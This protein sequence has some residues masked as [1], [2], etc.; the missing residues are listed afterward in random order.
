MK[1]VLEKAFNLHILSHQEIV[2]LLSPNEYDEL[3]FSYADEVRKKY[4]GDEIYLRALIE[5][6][7]ICQNNCLYCGIRAQNSKISR[8]KLSFEQIIET[9]KKA[10]DLGYKTVV[11]QSGEGENFKTEEIVEVI[12]EIKKMD[13]AVTLSLGE[14]NFEQYEAYKKAGADRYLIRIETTDKN[15][16][17]KM[18]PK[19]NFENRVRCLTDLK[20]LGY[21]VGT[22]SLVGLPNQTLSSLADDILFFKEIDADMIG[23]GPFIATENTPLENQQNG[24]FNL[25]RKMISIVRLL[26]PNINIPATTAMETIEKKGRILV[27]K[28]GANV[29]MPNITPVEYRQ[30]YSIY[31]DKSS[32]DANNLEELKNEFAKIGRKI[33]SKKG[34]R[35][36]NLEY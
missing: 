36:D 30:D 26:M 4:I 32:V 35:K 5:F 23:L 8:Y 3:L 10:C 1:K 17:E 19:M 21:E 34:F 2:D 6:S 29:V 16:Y 25:A 13:I 28:S 22:G 20:N 11:L 9:A 24:S 27:L 15:L 7:N 33:S 31:P 14:K 12:S 18:H